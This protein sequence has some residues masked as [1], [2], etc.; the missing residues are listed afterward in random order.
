[1]EYPHRRYLLYLLSK[2]L[3]SF[4]IMADCTD[5]CLL[6]PSEEDI[7]ALASDLG[8]P[9]KHWKANIEKSGTTFYRWLR[10]HRLLDA[11]RN[12][13][14]F[15]EARDFLLKANIRKDF[16]ALVLMKGDVEEARNELLLN[17]TDRL[18]PSLRVLSKY[19]EYFW[20]LGDMSQDGVFNF[21]RSNQEREELL[22]AVRGDLAQ[23]YGRLGLRQRIEAELFYDNLIALANQ[24]VEHARRSGPQN[25]NGSALMGIAALT[26]QAMDAVASRDEMHKAEVGG[27]L[28]S[29]KEEA[30]AFRMRIIEDSEIPSL[31]EIKQKEVIDAE[32]TEA[33][34]LRQFPG[35]K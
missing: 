11:W 35:A 8:P 20:N 32:F 3:T 17:Y 14:L 23:T 15:V 12:T 2:K 16:E 10:D 13:D 33:G 19:C 22:P 28:E 4:E 30:M 5:R 1:M 26:R 6:P 31:D 7:Q 27:V 34:N 21:L 25:L 24:Q 18:V 29:V 9:P